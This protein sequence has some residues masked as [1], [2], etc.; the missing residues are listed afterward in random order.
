MRTYQAFPGRVP[1]LVGKL[2]VLVLTVALAAGAV[3][4]VSALA[5]LQVFGGVGPLAIVAGTT[6]RWLPPNSV[7]VALFGYGVGLVLSR[8]LPTLLTVVSYIYVVPDVVRVVVSGASPWVGRPPVV[9]AD[10]GVVG[11]NHRFAGRLL[12]RDRARVRGIRG[13]HRH[14]G[15]AGAGGRGCSDGGTSGRVRPLRPAWWASP[16]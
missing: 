7:L 8:S 14:R 4:V 12:S 3:A 16:G 2:L 6:D 5:V 11:R 10:R 1:V 9:P 13:R 15:V